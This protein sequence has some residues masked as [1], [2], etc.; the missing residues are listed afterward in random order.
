M[1]REM[2]AMGKSGSGNI[3]VNMGWIVGLDR[4]REEEEVGVLVPWAWGREGWGCEEE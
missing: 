2:L 1:M 4:S 3:A